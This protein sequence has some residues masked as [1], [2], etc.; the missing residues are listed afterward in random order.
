[1][2]QG[3]VAVGEVEAA[4]LELHAGCITAAQLHQG[5]G[6][7]IE[8]LHQ[9]DAQGFRTERLAQ[10]GSFL[11][12]SAA[13]DQQATDGAGHACAYEV[14]KCLGANIAQRWLRQRRGLIDGKGKGIHGWTSA[15][16]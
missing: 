7:R 14:G 12:G 15:H 8:V 1:M 2:L 9:V 11:A 4:I 3:V 6:A 5:C 16:G 13:D 10:D